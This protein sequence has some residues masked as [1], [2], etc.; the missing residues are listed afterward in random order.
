MLNQ[1]FWE[2]TE[3]LLDLSYKAQRDEEVLPGKHAPTK[4]FLTANSMHVRIHLPA[5]IKPQIP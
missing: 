1:S 5:V 3:S 2:G 4:A